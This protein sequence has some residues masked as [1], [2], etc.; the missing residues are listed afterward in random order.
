LEL[1]AFDGKA[2]TEALTRA[3]AGMTLV[4]EAQAA[5]LRN[6]IIEQ[7]GKD[8]IDWL[9]ELAP[10]N[11]SWHDG[12]KLKLLYPEQA[13][14]EDGEPNSPEV[15]VKITECFALKDH[16]HICEGNVPVKLWLCSPDGKRI[17]STFNW[18]A[19]KTNTYPKLKPVLQRK[20]PGNT[21]I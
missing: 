14:D 12:R 6:A 13:R 2:I 9:N 3:F 17:E 15:Q 7:F 19:F 20:F 10:L 1:P 4:K 11:I 21:W 18:P 8:K 16:P 5:P